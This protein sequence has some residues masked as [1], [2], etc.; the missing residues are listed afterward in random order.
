MTPFR[1]NE[2]GRAGGRR[3]RAA[4]YLGAFRIC[5]GRGGEKLGTA[6]TTAVMIGSATTQYAVSCRYPTYC[7]S[8]DIRFPRAGL[9]HAVD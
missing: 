8:V 2:P 6:P 9:H 4:L 1:R 5:L 3:F 7:Y